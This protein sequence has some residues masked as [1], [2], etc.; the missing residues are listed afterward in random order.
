MQ[1]EHINKQISFKKKNVVL[2]FLCYN[3]LRVS[4][5]SIIVIVY[6]QTDVHDCFYTIIFSNF[7]FFHLKII[8]I[9][10]IIHYF[11]LT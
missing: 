5:T 7:N 2:T 10:K 8:L 6:N 3:F 11:F 4:Y 1:T 9:F